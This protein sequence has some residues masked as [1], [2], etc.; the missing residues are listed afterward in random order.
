MTANFCKF[1]DQ[2]EAYKLCTMLHKLTIKTCMAIMAITRWM[3]G[4][5]K[6]KMPTNSKND[7][8]IMT[9]AVKLGYTKPT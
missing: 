7:D 2:F 4:L 1:L 3:T 5:G 9:P 8:E 6:N